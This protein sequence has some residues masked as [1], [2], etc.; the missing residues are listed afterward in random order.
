MHANY[1]LYSPTDSFER[2][3]EILGQPQGNYVEVSEL[4]DRDNLTFTNGFYANCTA[5]FVD[6][7]DSSQLPDHY[8]RPKLAKLYRAYI[9][10]VVAILNGADY[11]RE[12]NIVGDGVWAVF[13]TMNSDH[14]LETAGKVR[15]LIMALNY[16]LQKAGYDA[17]P[18]EVGIGASCGRALMIKA[19]YSGSGI[20]EVVYMGDVVNHAAKLAAQGSK[21]GR[22]PILIANDLAY[23][24]KDEY[25]EMVRSSFDPDCFYADV[26]NKLMNEWY[27]VNC[28]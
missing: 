23:A 27:E 16:K 25:W 22:P 12:I 9:S 28:T 13:N 10:E 24:L 17:G 21:D 7:R 15:S 11:A 26:V 1:K 8:K 3:D 20:N 2:I 5:I 14:I 18:V 4:P 19:G 6:I